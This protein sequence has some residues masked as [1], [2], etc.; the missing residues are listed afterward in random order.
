MLGTLETTP[1]VIYCGRKQLAREFRENWLGEK[2]AMYLRDMKSFFLVSGLLRIFA[3]RFLG[4]TSK[5]RISLLK[6]MFV[7]AC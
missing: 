1:Y 3:F 5:W 4:M 2:V 6:D 7:N